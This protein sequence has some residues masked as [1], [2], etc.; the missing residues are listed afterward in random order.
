MLNEFGLIGLGLGVEEQTTCADNNR[1]LEEIQL[2][3]VPLKCLR[4]AY[5]VKAAAHDE[6]LI[7]QD[8]LTRVAIHKTTVR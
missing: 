8:V 5:D 3:G 2:I 6:F 4:V 1:E 7:I